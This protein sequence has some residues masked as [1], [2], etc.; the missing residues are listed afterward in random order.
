LADEI[1]IEDGDAE[2]KAKAA[3]ADAAGDKAPEKENTAEADTAK[4]PESGKPAGTDSSSGK[5]SGKA[6][7]DTQKADRKPDGENGKAEENGKTEAGGKPAEDRKKTSG[8][9]KEDT[10]AGK[11]KSIFHRDK[12]DREIDELAKKNA[13]LTDRYKRMMAEYANY[14]KRSEKEKASMFDMGAKSIIEKVLPALDNFERGLGGLK[15]EQKSDPF[16][17]GMQQVY[18]SLMKDLNDAGLEEIEA[19]GKPF[20]PNLHNAV[21]HVDDD[22]LGENTVAEV[23]QKGYTWKGTVVRHAMVKVA[24]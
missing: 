6:E 23:F 21:M 8:A 22:S 17:Q 11:G 18:K 14:Q 9:E 10:S 16:A 4:Q 19:Q 13:D 7:A 15:D 24:N 1:N 12:K 3:Q 5:S 2:A 20:D